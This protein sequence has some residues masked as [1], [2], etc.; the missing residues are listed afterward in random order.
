MPYALKTLFKSKLQSKKTKEHL[1]ISYIRPVF[2]YACATWASIRGNDEKLRLFKRKVLRKIYGP[3]FNNKEHKWEIRTN[4]KL[5][6]I[7]KREDVVQ[8]TGGTRIEWV[9]H[10]WWADG[11]MLKGALTYMAMAKRPRGRPR[12]RWKDSV[13]ELFEEIGVAGIS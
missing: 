5:Y 3:I 12:K 13:K 1:F 9:G 10:I 7:Y 4:S 8:F 11:S 6:Q 2:T